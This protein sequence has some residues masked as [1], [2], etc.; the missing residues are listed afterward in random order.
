MPQNY[1]KL[2]RRDLLGQNQESES[3]RR[4]PFVFHISFEVGTSL[5]LSENVPW[6]AIGTQMLLQILQVEAPLH[7]KR[8]TVDDVLSTSH[9]Q[10]PN[11]TIELVCLVPFSTL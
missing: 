1:T 9:P 3:Q 11:E 2:L 7:R 5:H 4:D 6:K 8:V 10:T